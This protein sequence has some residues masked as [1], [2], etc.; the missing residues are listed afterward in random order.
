MEQGF[1][2]LILDKEKQGLVYWLKPEQDFAKVSKF[3]EGIVDPVTDEKYKPLILDDAWWKTRLSFTFRTNRMGV[4]ANYKMGEHD[5]EPTMELL[6]ASNPT[7]RPV[8]KWQ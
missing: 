8:L 4:I 5:Y 1:K 6:V 7:L 3:L 2:A